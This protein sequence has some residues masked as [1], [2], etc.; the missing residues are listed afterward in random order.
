MAKIRIEAIRVGARHRKDLGDIDELAKSL[1]TVGLL[2][3]IGVTPD[4]ELVFGQRR[5]VAAKK[6]GWKA[7][8]AR[9]V[10][11]DALLAER[12]ENVERKDF[13]PSERV[14]I[15]QA[16][17]ARTGERRGRPSKEKPADLPEI[18]AGRETREHA[19]AAAGF[20]STTTYRQAKL[21]VEKA[22]PKVREAM[23][24]GEVSISAAAQLARLPPE[25]QAAIVH[26]VSTGEAKDFRAARALVNHEARTRKLATISQK[27]TALDGW[28]KYSLLLAD[29]PWRYDD[30]T[31][32]PSRVIE[33][34]YPTMALEE[35]CAM[36][37][38]IDRVSTDS[39]ILFLWVTNPLLEEGL[40]VMRAW[41]FSY[42][43]NFAWDKEIAGMGY[44]ARGRHELLLLGT[45]GEPP[46]PLAKNRSDSVIRER[47]TKHSRKPASAYE[48]IE[49]MYPSLARLELFARTA[50]EGWAAWGPEASAAE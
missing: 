38:Q 40:E 11:V 4:R 19:A 25:E 21:V 43:T 32:S 30:Q 42:K 20:D 17:E 3:A 41:G 5:L 35:I 26:A 24:A 7:I 6:L 1:A 10:D 15:A 46:P 29:P 50:R 12:D 28:Q 9:I 13:T 22:V 48:L 44:W 23:D 2:Q 27:I 39:A 36:R 34:H 31:T 45:K 18:P 47:R 14:S 37:P 49:R 8:E 16:I 33:N